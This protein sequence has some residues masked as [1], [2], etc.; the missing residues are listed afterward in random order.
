MTCFKKLK[1]KKEKENI[2]N[3][4]V[5]IQDAIIQPQIKHIYENIQG[6][7]RMSDHLDV[8]NVVKL[9]NKNQI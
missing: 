8:L 9:S 7:T 3:T 2:F 6:L 4:F 1:V 5:N